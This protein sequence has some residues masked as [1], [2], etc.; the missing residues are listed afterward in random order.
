MKNSADNLKERR[1]LQKILKQLEKWHKGPPEIPIKDVAKVMKSLDVEFLP[2]TQGVKRNYSHELLRDPNKQIKE[3]GPDG[4]F[5]CH[6]KHPSA[7]DN[8]KFRKHD[9]NRYIYKALNEIIKRKMENL[10]V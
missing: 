9:F 7:K 8:P 10:D 2:M 3:V 1:N 5:G 6:Q 4:R